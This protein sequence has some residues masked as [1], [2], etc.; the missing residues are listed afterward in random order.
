MQTKKFFLV[1]LSYVVLTLSTQAQIPFKIIGWFFKGKGDDVTKFVL[2]QNKVNKSYHLFNEFGRCIDDNVSLKYN[3]KNVELS[4]INTSTNLRRLKI[5]E[6]N[7][8]SKV[9]DNDAIRKKEHYA[10][11]QKTRIRTHGDPESYEFNEW[12][13]RSMASLIIKNFEDLPLLKFTGVKNAK[14]DI[15][16]AISCNSHY[17]I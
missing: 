17:L 6:F 9:I 10:R 8:F 14:V 4:S 5:K 16:E 15:E 13:G 3:K 12:Y 11:L 1:V 7:N 2:K